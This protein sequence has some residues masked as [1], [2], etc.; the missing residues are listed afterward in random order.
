MKLMDT[1]KWKSVLVPI[2][3]YKEIKTDA[4]TNGRTISGQLRV[5][6]DVY[7]QSHEK[8]LDVSHKVAYK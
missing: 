3:V 6:F 1:T 7:S 5:M 8:T 2:E 4:A